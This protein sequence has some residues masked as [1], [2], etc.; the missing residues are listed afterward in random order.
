MNYTN[1]LP[2]LLFVVAAFFNPTHTQENSGYC[3]KDIDLVFALDASG[4][5]GEEGYEQIKRFAKGIID[6]F[7]IAATKTHVAIVTFSEYGEVQLK[8]TDSFDKNEIFNRIDNLDYPGYRTATDDALRVLDQQVFSL[9]GGMRQ[10][11]A[12]VLIFLTDGK[13]TL[14]EQSVESAVAPIKE[15]GVTIYTVG[16]TD[17][18][19]KTELE[20]IAS[21][22]P[23]DHSFEVAEFDELAGIIVDVYTKACDVKIGKCR[24]PLTPFECTGREEDECIGDGECDGTMKCCSSGCSNKCTFPLLNCLTAVDVAFA[25]DS[26]KSV[27]D[28]AFIDMKNF[29]KDIVDSFVVSQKEARFASL[30]YSNDAE[31][32]F[33]FVRHASADK[34]KRAIDALPHKKSD[35]RVDK[36]LELAASDIFSLQ[37]GVRSRRPMVLI[38]FFDGDVSKDMGDLERFAAPLKE[39]GVKIVAVGVGPEVNTYQLAKIATSSNVIFKARDFDTL[40]PELYTIAEETCSEKPGECPVPTSQ[41]CAISA[42]SNVCESDFDCNGASKCCQ[43]KCGSSVCV[44]PTNVCKRKVD[45]AFAVHQNANPEEFQIMKHFVE[46]SLLRFE[47]NQDRAHAALISYGKDPTVV[48]DFND[49]Q[50]VTRRLFKEINLLQYNPGQGTLV[51]VLATACDRIFCKIGGTRPDVPKMLVVL[52]APHAPSNDVE[53]NR[54]IKTLQQRGVDVLFLAVGDDV[55]VQTLQ[56]VTSPNAQVI[57]RVLL[58]DSFANLVQYG[59]DIPEFACSEAG[60]VKPSVNETCVSQPYK[61]PTHC[62]K[63]AKGTRGQH[64]IFGKRGQPGVRGKGGNPGIR[65]PQG[66]QGD[67]GRRGPA[68]PEGA[69]GLIGLPGY[70]GFNGIPGVPGVQ[71]R[72]GRDGGCGL[73]GR[74]GEAGTAGV[75][76]FS[77]PPGYKGPAGPKGAKGQPAVYNPD[78]EIER[79]DD[80]DPGENGFLGF[81]GMKGDE[82]M[83]GMPGEDGEDGSIGLDGE[84]GDTGEPGLATS[85]VK[86][87]KGLPGDFGPPGKP[88]L[89]WSEGCEKGKP[90]IANITESGDKGIKGVAGDRGQPG[91]N[92]DVNGIQ[93]ADGDKGLRGDPGMDAEEGIAGMKG[94]KGEEGIKGVNGQPGDGGRDGFRGFPGLSGEDGPAGK[95][96]NKGKRGRPGEPKPPSLGPKGQVGDAGRP[97]FSGFP[98]LEGPEGPQGP[99]GDEGSRGF[100]GEF[101]RTGQKGGEGAQGEKGP[102]GEIGDIGFKGISGEQGAK[103][104]PASTPVAE[105]GDKGEAGPKGEVGIIGLIGPPGYAGPRGPVTIADCGKECPVTKGFKGQQGDNGQPGDRGSAG[106][107]GS[108][109]FPAEPCPTCPP[110]PSGISGVAGFPGKVGFKGRAGSDGDPGM[111]GVKGVMGPKGAVGEPGINGKAGDKG[112]PGQIGAKGPDADGFSVAERGEKGNPGSDGLNGKR[113]ADGKA[114]ERGRKGAAGEPGKRG[115]M[116]AK[117]NAGLSGEAGANGKDGKPGQKGEE[118]ETV[119]GEPGLTG[120]EGEEGIMGLFGEPGQ[121]GKKGERGSEPN[122][123]Q[124]EQMKKLSPGEKGIQGPDGDAGEPG[125][126]GP[127]GVIGPGGLQGP[128]GDKGGR[129]PG[130]VK[131]EVGPKGQAGDDGDPGTAG[132]PGRFGRRGLPGDAGKPG[133]PGDSV[134]KGQKGERGEAG[135]EGKRGVDASAI[136]C[137][138]VERIDIAFLIDSSRS[139]TQEDFQRQKEFIREIVSEFP[140]G[141]EKSLVGVI[142]YGMGANVEIRFSDYTDEKML[143][144]RVDRLQHS[145]AT[146]SRLDEALQLAQDRLFTRE[147]GARIG[148]QKTRQALVI[149]GDGYLSGGGLLGKQLSGNALNSANQIKARGTLVFSLA[150]GTEKN[151]YLLQR[152]VSD[153]NY[154]LDVPTYSFLSQKI[155]DLKIALSRSSGCVTETQKGEP[156]RNNTVK[157]KPGDR[158]V[159]GVPGPPGIE[160][161][162]GFIGNNGPKGYR[163]STIPGQKGEQGYE[164]LNGVKGEPGM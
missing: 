132:V 52:T 122:A 137:I 54:R 65:G 10:G 51:D 152:F 71:G 63:G 59:R 85:F 61:P 64:G 36:A 11:A 77:G 131:G 22:P 1:L 39:Y 66:D 140:V 109:G 69:E 78:L 19:N 41:P 157:G 49:P 14:C 34:I 114:G 110:G 147:A 56:R 68:G 88:G 117:G 12:Q 26:S 146:E 75:A 89:V 79:G 154:Y 7:Q 42:L 80:G 123:E 38:V 25:L 115:E 148:D 32:S 162:E 101:G 103:G 135:P 144:E 96:G 23:R 33:D 91:Y 95:Q 133:L 30:I 28:E 121:K 21:E 45:V 100:P 106:P 73:P 99:D 90:C 141:P 47:I 149:L 50:D 87:E 150:V 145:A 161:P 130:G 6:Q 82:G 129:G 158:G 124:K 29:A 163:G 94:S 43:D 8:L 76:G 120:D 83:L 105:V 13:C 159:Q 2:L 151:R 127:K 18:I 17:K 111:A 67:D 15:R 57:D 74:P 20:V 37:G 40:L 46:Q 24:K 126:E 92:S 113:G 155:E 102:D 119:R 160:G 98:G 44:G 70:A 27:R 60:S 35:T 97:G 31:V 5:V 107:E 164:G 93:G 9:S 134:I 138:N 118:G 139:V 62:V 153:D 136:G 3:T 143:L 116:G 128:A 84:D 55:D 104:E 81:K 72:L 48:F 125:I 53:L 142:K 4:S 58:A 112:E 16:V 156:G 108:K 86:G